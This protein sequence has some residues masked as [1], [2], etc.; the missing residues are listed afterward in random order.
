[1]DHLE[2]GC[3]RLWAQMSVSPRP[4][5]PS[6]PGTRPTLRSGHNDEAAAAEAEEGGG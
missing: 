3:L 4:E 1:M 2:S 5:A 6:G